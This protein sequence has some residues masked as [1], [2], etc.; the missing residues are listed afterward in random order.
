MNVISIKFMAPDNLATEDDILD[1]IHE[2][3]PFGGED[4]EID[5]IMEETC[6]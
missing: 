6:P 5:I 2:T 1:W 3:F 4:V